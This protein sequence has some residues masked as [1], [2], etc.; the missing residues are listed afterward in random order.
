[1][2]ELIRE[3][4]H[5]GLTGKEAAV[6][7]AAMELGPSVAQDIAKKAKV[8]RATTYVMIDTLKGRGLV[9]SFTK[10]KKKYFV[11]ESPDRLMSMIR[12]QRQELEGK[13]AE[14]ANILPQLA[15]LYNVEGAKP[16]IRFLEGLEG[17]KTIHEEVYTLKGEAI[18]II[19]FDDAQDFVGRVQAENYKKQAQA[20]LSRMQVPVR[21]LLVIE[22][23]NLLE[24]L[25]KMQD[26]IQLRII[27]AEDFPIHGEITIR[28]DRVI[29][30]SYK[31]ALVAIVITSQ[32][33]ADTLRAM[34]ELAWI[35]AA[36]YPLH[37]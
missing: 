1:M 33:I 19:P 24:H 26:N 4:T 7:L 28:D 25:P 34:F 11:A 27:P 8:N 10:G 12:L 22:N 31:S 32:V 14:F 5:L 2:E 29:M 17:I 30:F 21:A 3:L 37:K 18:Q 35:G 13:E 6:Y 9:S 15:A 23:K 16:Q 20:K 36:K